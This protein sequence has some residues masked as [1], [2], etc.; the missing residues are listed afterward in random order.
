MRYP[1]CRRFL[2]CLLLLLILGAAVAPVQGQESETDV[3]VAQAIL[4][5]DD[6]R[7][8]EALGYL[9]EATSQ[10]PNNVE[11]WYYTGLVYI[12]QQR[13]PQAAEAL[14]RARAL[15]PDDFSVK[16]LLGVAYFAQE[17]Y[18]LAEPLLEQAFRERPKTEALGY[19]VGFMRYRKKQYAQ[20]VEA[21]KAETS[22]NPAIQQLARFYSGLALA[23]MGLPERAAAELD[24]ATR[25]LTGTALTG[26]AER[27][28]DSFAAAAGAGGGRF[29]AEVRLGFTY[30]TNVKVNP[31]PSHDPIAESLR[32]RSSKSVGELAALTLSYDWLRS[33]PWEST[34]GYQF[35]ENYVNSFPDFSVQ[36]H[37]GVLG[38]TY[39][40]AF[41]TGAL[42][43][44]RFLVGLQY[45]YDYQTLGGEQ[46][47]QRHTGTGFGTIQ[48]NAPP[49]GRPWLPANVTTP[50]A[51]I[52]G[53]QFAKTIDEPLPREQSRSGINYMIGLSH[54]FYW[55]GDKHWLRLGYQWDMDDT[56]G[57]DFQYRG[58][59][60]LAG[61]QYTLPRFA[62]RLRY[63][64][65]VH[66]RKYL[67]ADSILPVIVSDDRVL[68]N[69]SSTQRYDSEQN[70]I[71]KLE[72]PL[73]W[74]LRQEGGATRAPLTLA[75]EYQIGVT[76]SNLKVFQFDRNVLAVSIS[77]Q[78]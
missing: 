17:R 50:V 25:G 32:Y 6:K 19:Y 30:D 49:E 59:R 35:F 8:D 14:E 27:L 13:L 77:Y 39:R 72:Q 37:V 9:R 57:R 23:V 52:Q 20:A 31:S 51:R 26:P 15:A 60:I 16:F 5:Y 10:D 71:F 76:R 38:A 4:A 28:R 44:R 29:H 46:F 11:A 69:P 61:V 53:K 48:W 70:H 42:A 63:D 12:A 24:A 78:Y 64:L 55:S 7:Y 62:T 41:E 65:D 33:G 66:L 18:D 21:L 45:A 36:D 54:T 1:A 58:D 47:L 3:Y 75:V 22:T 40:G 2:A 43:G 74:L 56:D 34:V 68:N 67:H 73:P